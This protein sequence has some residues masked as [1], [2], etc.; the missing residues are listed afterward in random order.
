[1]YG[2][3]CGEYAC[4]YLAI[5]LDTFVRDKELCRSRRAIP[6]FSSQD[7][8][9]SPYHKKAE[10]NIPPSPALPK[11]LN[12]CTFCCP[13]FCQL[14]MKVGI[15]MDISNILQIWS[16]LAGY[17]ELA[18]G[19]KPIRHREIFNWMNNNGFKV[20]M[21]TLKVHIPARTSVLKFCDWNTT[22]FFKIV[23]KFWNLLPFWPSICLK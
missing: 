21:H 15:I 16:K 4:W 2:D 5:L 23:L 19:F 17:E 8:Y 10:S 6:H 13:F 12:Y 20:S 18:L 7:M 3:Q 9:N 11:Q 22:W 1:M 14:S